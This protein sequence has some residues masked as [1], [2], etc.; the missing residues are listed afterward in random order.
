MGA[1]SGLDRPRSDQDS[2]TE[3]DELDRFFGQVTGFLADVTKL[4]VNTIICTEITGNKMPPSRAALAEVL[5]AYASKLHGVEAD[6]ARTSWTEA[7]R[8]AISSALKATIRDE[9]DGG[10][11][12]L[13]SACRQLD[14]ELQGL[15][16][17]EV[18]M[19]DASTQTTELVNLVLSRLDRLLSRG[20]L[21]A[22]R[23]FTHRQ[24]LT[25]RKAWELREAEVL[26]QTTVQ[27][28]GDLITR[29]NARHV[30]DDSGLQIHN[31]AV[32]RATA[33]WRVLAELLVSL[34]RRRN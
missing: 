25:L 21:P 14:D 9:S 7:K 20:L 31:E 32:S 13:V 11:S 30:S 19:H 8:A 34:V 3:Q 24:L 22:P 29:I 26:A 10:L 12:P 23:S 17:T 33:G 16:A 2:A 5:E 15:Q 18:A 27:L 6:A 28:D 4:E 1:N